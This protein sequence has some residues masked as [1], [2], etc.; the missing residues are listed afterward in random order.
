MAFYAYSSALNEL[1]LRR[2]QL[3]SV[4]DDETGENSPPR[5]AAWRLRTEVTEGAAPRI[6]FLSDTGEF[7]RGQLPDG[8]II[9]PT[10]PEE[11]RAVWQRKGLPT[12]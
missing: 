7:V 10:R 3:T 1:K 9:A 6:Y 12:N 4:R 8:S 11:L 2:E 5:N